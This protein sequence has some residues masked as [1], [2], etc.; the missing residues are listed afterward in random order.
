MHDAGNE[1]NNPTYPQKRERDMKNAVYL[2]L[3]L[4]ITGCTEPLVMIPGGKLKGDVV[5]VP[6][7]WTEVPEVV[8]L[9][10]QPLDPYSLNI[11]AVIANG[12]LHVATQQAKWV[13]MLA[14]DSDVRVKIDGK[15]YELTAEKLTKVGELEAVEQAYRKKYELE[16]SMLTETRVYRLTARG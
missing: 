11:W 10:V 15:I 7:N 5:P 2:L 12:H 16:E 1:Q 3:A 6:E 8:Q 13:P 9:E 4:I 14:A